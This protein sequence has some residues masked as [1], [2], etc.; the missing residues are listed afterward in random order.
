MQPTEEAMTAMLK[1][2]VHITLPENDGDETGDAMDRHVAPIALALQM[3]VPIN[4]WHIKRA[5]KRWANGVGMPYPLLYDSGVYYKEDPPGEENWK[6]IPAVLADGHGDCIPLSALVLRD[7]YETVSLAALRPGDRIMGERTWTDVREVMRTGVKE[8]L[9]FKLS[10]GCTL[11]CSPEHRLFRDVDG[12]QE[13]IRAREAKVGDDLMLADTIPFADR[14]GLDWPSSLSTLS[15]SDRAW[16]LGVF[17]ADGWVDS[18]GSP[19]RAS[20]SGQD[21]KPKEEQKRRVEALM[22]SV[23][24]DTRWHRK[25]IAINDKEIAAFFQRCGHLAMNKRVPSL[26]L[27]S[28]EAVRHVLKGLEADASIET[29]PGKTGTIVY[30]TTSPGLALQL[31]I[32][33]RMLGQSVGIRRVD[34]H[35]GFGTHPIY[36]V[37]PRLRNRADYAIRRDKHFGRIRSISDGGMEMCG[38]ITTSTGKFWLPESDVLVH[39]CDR[40]VA[41]R[42]AELLVMGIDCEPVIK[43]QLLPRQVMIQSGYPAKMVPDEGILM[44]HCCIRF[45]DGSIEDPSKI[46]GMGGNFTSTV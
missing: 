15:A 24:I 5:L 34:H 33:H 21:G 43:Y 46:L 23:K 40:L 36:R 11:R 28:E 44:I 19:C 27:D 8:L 16:L 12:R 37:T 18:D 26:Q 9:A 30:G 41:W 45:P 17:V 25:Y 7:D 20:I 31:R 3:M 2:L 32:L 29:R 13:E 35:G 22:A 10:N 14:D 6:D 38:D 1:P 42:T 4:I 39:N